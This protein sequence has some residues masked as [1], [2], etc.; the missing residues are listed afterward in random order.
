MLRGIFLLVAAATVLVGAPKKTA[1]DDY[2]A[3]PDPAYSW[4]LAHTVPGRGVTGYI[5][6]MT[7]QT[8]GEGKQVDRTKWVHWVTVIRPKVL[9]SSTGLLF[10]T[11]GANDGRS[12]TT[13]D[14]TLAGIAEYTGSV[15]TELRMV[16]NQSLVFGD[17]PTPGRKRSE[18]AI[19]A[20][21]WRKF[22]ETGDTSW[23]LRLPMT[24]A[25]V[26]AM[27]TVT[28]FTKSGEGGGQA[29]DKFFVAGASK[30]G[31]TTLTT[32]AVDARVAGMAPIVIDM[33]NVVPSFQHHYRAYGFWAPSVGDYFAEG[34]MDEMDNPRYKTLM[35][36]VEPYEY[37]DRL[38]MPK[39]IMNSAGDQFF[40]PDSWKFYFKDLK[41]EKHLR[42]I[43]NSDHSLRNTDAYESLIAFYDS[44][45][46][47][48][49]RP[50]YSWKVKKDG[51]IVVET[52]DQPA[53]VKL[54]QATNPNGRD[55]R[56]EQI[57]PQ[58]KSSDLAP[59]KPG[60][61][62][63]KVEKPAKGYT[64]YF[65]EL[66]FPSGGKYP[67]KFTSGVVVNPDTYSFGPPVKGRTKLGGRPAKR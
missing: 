7:S 39:F 27:D 57:G 9:K 22:L 8:W 10:V 46:Q 3:R 50:K 40:L 30:R 45:L 65:V 49:P 34:V 53:A 63:A 56:L 35:K 28:A 37:R 66:T 26:R 47:N 54:W 43:P 64:A 17:D 62:V 29:V 11:G 2:V 36:L 52:G 33:L 42:Y 13:V 23:P 51:S 25:V 58:Y 61:Y 44:M 6:E 60:H 48:K 20:Y 5:L 12:R 21:T 18:D 14:G 1:L 32:G 55:F 41:G 31:W 24:K 4:K 38:T 15:V 16:P 19:I 59:A 67:Y